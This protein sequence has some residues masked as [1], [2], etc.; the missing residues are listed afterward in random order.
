MCFTIV[1]KESVGTCGEQIVPLMAVA[2]A[3]LA[4]KGWL[5][6]T[7]LPGY[8]GDGAILAEVYGQAVGFITY[9]STEKTGTLSL[10]F[11]WVEPKHRNK[12]VYRKLWDELVKYAQEKKFTRIDGTTHAGNLPMRACFEH[13]GR[14]EMWVTSVYYVKPDVAPANVPFKKGG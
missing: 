2:S 12:G 1:H 13:L 7:D 14:K 3:E 10:I 8:Y 5:P 6:L 11:G 9:R 4:M